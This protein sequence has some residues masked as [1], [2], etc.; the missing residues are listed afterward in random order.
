MTV[1]ESVKNT[2]VEQCSVNEDII[3]NDATI[4]NIGIDS[5]DVVDVIMALEDEY[6]IKIPDEDIEEI[7]TINDLV[8]IIEKLT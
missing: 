8:E 2:I 1:F 3:T 6:E 4:E 7:E 5:L